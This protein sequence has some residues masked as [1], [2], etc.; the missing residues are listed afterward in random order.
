LELEFQGVRVPF[1][2]GG[3]VNVERVVDDFVLFCMLVG[4]DFLPGAC[5]MAARLF[6]CRVMLLRVP[7]TMREES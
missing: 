2:P 1:Q 3:A 4:N 5:V 6:A 7:S